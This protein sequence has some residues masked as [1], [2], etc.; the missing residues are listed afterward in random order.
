MELLEVTGWASTAANGAVE[1]SETVGAE[2]D[3]STL[4]DVVSVAL[5]AR[6][7]ELLETSEAVVLAVEVAF[8]SGVAADAVVF[9]DI[10]SSLMSAIPISVPLS[11]G[12]SAMGKVALEPAD[13][14]VP[15]P[16]TPP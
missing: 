5:E 7:V 14:S 2:T 8:R 3:A 11:E 9:I 15:S 6:V 10:V 12:A 4:A 1:L 13:V 16:L